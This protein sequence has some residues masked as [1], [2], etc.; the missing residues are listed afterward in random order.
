M[1]KVVKM[2][3]DMMA[4]LKKEQVDDDKKKEY[5]TAELDKVGD[6]KAE[7]DRALK[8]LNTKLADHK[9]TLESVDSEIA[10]LKQGIQDLDL[11]VAVATQQRKQE[12]DEFMTLLANNQAAIELIE[13]A[14]NRL[15]KFY[16]PKLYKPPAPKKL[17][18]EERIS[19]NFGA[20]QQDVPEFV[21][22]RTRV[23]DDMDDAFGTDDFMSYKKQAEESNGVIAMMDLLKADLV[24]EVTE[25]KVEE[26]DSQEEYE[27]M[28]KA[29]AEKRSIDSKTIVEKEGGKAE[30]SEAVNVVTKDAK[31]E[32]K[33]LGATIKILADLHNECDFLLQ[34][35]DQRKQSRSDE[36]EGLSKAKA[37]LAGADY[38]F[39]QIGAHT[40]H[41]RASR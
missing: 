9:E 40:G 1:G 17:T 18:E 28:M 8:D 41:L 23:R 20:F 35:Y 10:A 3:E 34:A 33:E 24:K 4:L 15:N 22:V 38:S 29:A 26:K 11:S 6:T 25:A 32:T 5:C 36:I 19:Q 13:M 31:G 16:N 30:A 14:K 39:I 7:S 27:I 37:V 21:Q 12:H 2:I